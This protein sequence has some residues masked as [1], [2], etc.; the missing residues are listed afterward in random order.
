MMRERA[1]VVQVVRRTGVFSPCLRSFSGGVCG[2]LGLE[3]RR[4]RSVCMWVWVFQ[5]PLTALSR[6][7]LPASCASSQATQAHVLGG[8]SS[9]VRRTKL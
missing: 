8:R 7:S 1:F 6:T 3:R 5:A 2:S 9:S 4:Q